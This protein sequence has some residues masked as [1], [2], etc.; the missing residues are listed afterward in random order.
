MRR[1]VELALIDGVAGAVCGAPGGQPR[2]VFGFT[3]AGGRIARIDILADPG[4]LSGLD[5]EFVDR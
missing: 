5:L 3:L 4:V 1:A 2:V